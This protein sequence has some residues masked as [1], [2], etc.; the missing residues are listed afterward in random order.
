MDRKDRKRLDDW[1]KFIVPKIN[2]EKLLPKLIENKVYNKDDVNIQRWKKNLSSEDTVKEIYVTIKTRG[3]HAFRN[4]ILSLRE[5]GYED[6]ANILEEKDHVNNYNTSFPG[7]GFWCSTA[8]EPLKIKVLKAKKFVDGEYNSIGRYP[9][10]S[11]PRGMVLLIT[12]IYYNSPEEKPRISAKHDEDNLNKL[13]TE[14]GFQ[15]VSYQN[16][17]GEQ[18]RDAVKTFSKRDDLT[19]VDSCFVIVTSHGTEDKENNTEIQGTDYHSASKQTNYEKVLCS[20]ICD[21]FTVE[22][23]PQLANKPKIF[24][25]QLCRGKKKQK[26]VINDRIMTDSCAPPNTKT[27]ESSLDIFRSRSTRNY[28]DMLV[29]HSTLPG[30]VSYRDTITGSWFIQNLCKIFMNHACTTH[31]QDLFSL[32]DSE[33]KNL[34][35]IN[36]ECQTSS[37]QSLGF[38]K[39]CYLHPGLFEE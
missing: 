27:D 30:Y 32:V 33:L 22:S 10:R 18:I 23:C 4:F 25:F 28:S 21:Y 17:T 16:L 1:C 6:I 11:K 29:V 35:T 12:N 2:M 15:V 13:F 7:Q 14:I 36:N 8:T 34:R 20:D 38:H 9:M 3:P 37:I 39:H 5:C 24:V 19:K 31:V 26:A